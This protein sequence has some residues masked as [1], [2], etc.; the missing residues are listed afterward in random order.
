MKNS[1]GKQRLPYGQ[2]II[3]TSD[4][5]NWM[6]P[7]GSTGTV[8]AHR[9]GRLTSDDF[10]E[11]FREQFVLFDGEPEGL[12]INPA[13]IRRWHMA[14]I[15]ARTTLKAIGRVRPRLGGKTKEVF[16]RLLR[17]ESCEEDLEVVREE[18]NEVW[19]DSG[20]RAS[21]TKRLA[22]Y[23]TVENFLNGDYEA[24]IRAAMY[25]LPRKRRSARPSPRGD[26]LGQVAST[27]G[28]AAHE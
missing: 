14:P 17:G 28:G 22:A 2:R 23:E 25:A 5:N 20:R 18:C 12:R 4:I 1:A 9:S 19:N 3:I 11:R 10:W 6:L 24:A 27:L 16:D 7:V 13:Q 15:T 21:T 8:A 26:S